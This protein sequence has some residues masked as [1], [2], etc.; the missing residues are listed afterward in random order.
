MKK[1]NFVWLCVAVLFLSSNAMAQK[2]LRYNLK[3]GEKYGLKQLT[4][5]AI[6]QNISGMAQNITNTIGGDVTVTIKD[7]SGDVYTSEV[8]FES[9]LF[10]MESAMMNMTY[11]SKDESA[12][13]NN[14]LNKTFSLIV[15][16]PFQMKFDHRGN[17]LE[18]TGFEEVVNKLIA[19]FGDNPQQGEMMKQALSGQFS[20][21]SMKHSMSSMLIVYPDEK[22]KVGTQ[23]TSNTKLVQPV[24]INNT[25]NYNID[26]VSK[27]VV[28]LSGTGTLATVEGQSK[29]QGG[30]TQ[31]FDLKGDMELTANIN[32]QTGWPSEVK[33]TQNM[34]GQVA[35]ESAQ[36]PAPMEVPM[37]IKTESTFTTM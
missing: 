22:I 31:H 13:Q 29:E 9:M 18:V 5:Q 1:L 28:S 19:A 26:A 30:M 33:L 3:V 32:A 37:K 35:I 14:P 27:D 15:G 36:L 7:K 25:F 12:D 10:K 24:A 23:W 4:T 21:E 11:D 20:N 34:D 6:E 16:H 17:I 8:V 2:S